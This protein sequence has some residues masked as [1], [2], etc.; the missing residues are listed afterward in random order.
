MS[1]SLLFGALPERVVDAGGLA[2]AL[3]LKASFDAGTSFASATAA[4][5]VP[6]VRAEAWYAG[7]PML[8]APLRVLLETTSGG[9]TRAFNAADA[10]SGT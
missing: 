1:S 9:F 8:R 5:L 3:C 7:L 2:E 4:L 6:V 10:V